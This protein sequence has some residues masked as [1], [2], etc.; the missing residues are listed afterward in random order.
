MEYFWAILLILGLML[1]QV[2]QIF[3]LPANWLALALVALWKYVYP[4]SMTWNYVLLL[5]V[6]AAMG[7]ALEFALQAWGAGRYGASVRGNLG[8]IVGAIAG[9]IFGASFLFGL[10]ALIGALGGA[11]LGCLVA[12]MPGR[13]RPEALRAAKGAFVGKALGFTVKTAIGASMVILSIP[14]I[15]P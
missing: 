11:W 1:S 3:S 9:A 10:G 15:W 13:T 7:E 12:E 5:G 8:G 4:E 6:A 2:L 14:R